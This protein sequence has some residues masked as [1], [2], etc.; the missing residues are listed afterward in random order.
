MIDIEIPL[1][2]EKTRSYR[3]LER[4]PL[5]LSVSLLL[6][7][8]VL[9]L[10]DARLAAFFIIGYLLIWF[11]RGVGLNVRVFQGYNTMK[12]HERLPW[13]SMLHDVET[14]EV[15]ATKVPAWHKGNIERSRVL[16]GAVK[17]SETIHVLMIAVYNEAREVVEPTI[18]SVLAQN[19]N[20]KKVI[21]ILAYEERG[22]A[23][24]A[25]QSKD[26]IKVYGDKFMF[27]EAI[28]HPKDMPHEVIGKGGN[29]T[30]AGRI[31][32]KR[33][34]ARKIDPLKVLLT[35]LDSDNRPHPSYLNALTYTFCLCTDPKTISFQPIP[36]Y[37]N[38]IWDVPAL[39][40]VIATGNSFWNLVLSLRPHAIRN[41]SAHAQSMATLIDTDFWSVRTIVEDGHQYWRTY[42]RYD[43]IHEVYPIYVPIYQDAVLSE[44]YR[45]TLK[46]QFIQIRRWA[47]GAS[48]IAY[49]WTNMFI[50]PNQISKRNAIPKIWRLIESHVS[51]A[52]GP[53]LLAFS[54][55]VPILFNPE[56]IA[57]NQLPFIVSNIQRVALIGLAITMY[58]SFKSLPPKP[59]RYKRHRTIF[60]VL[61][62][63][64]LPVTTIAYNSMA[65]LYAQYRLFTG[66]Y[67]DKFDVTEKAVVRE[68]GKTISNQVN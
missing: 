34:E 28:E 30:F 37:T 22:G 53:L 63:V 14:G 47:Y 46:A 43:G 68:D 48:D 56:D 33:L 18:Q 60:M 9:S 24:I 40:R 35:T 15:T 23:D 66:K 49:V 12:L 39:M 67:L 4:L 36:I 29:I 54:A 7:P 57:A 38:N 64:L 45:R 26:L 21:L 62:W 52:T 55:F 42:F 13:E 16:P 1:Q 58:L 17:P 5:I 20:M 8:F 51:W 41:F 50:K 59:A 44:G 25:A 65:A 10:I 3:W 61:Q 19:Y 11:V 2:P 27:A 6:L 32:K 31:L